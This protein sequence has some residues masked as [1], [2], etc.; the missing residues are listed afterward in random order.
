[1]ER[2]PA[3]YARARCASHV[4]GQRGPFLT[5]SFVCDSAQPAARR[6]A[7][8]EEATSSRAYRIDVRNLE[9]RLAAREGGEGL[10]WRTSPAVGD[11]D[12][13]LAHLK[14]GE[15]VLCGAKCSAPTDNCSRIC[16]HVRIGR[17]ATL[18][19]APTSA[20]ARR[21]ATHAIDVLQTAGQSVMDVTS[22]GLRIDRARRRGALTVVDNCFCSRR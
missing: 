12:A 4:N 16:W 2:R 21:A 1:M 7:G 8:H 15:Q 3:P 19:G 13:V 5:A 11:P 20:W 10:T 6:F 18:P 14:A 22:G 9:Q 17:T